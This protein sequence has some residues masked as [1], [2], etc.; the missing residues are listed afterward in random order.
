[1]PDF[2]SAAERSEPAGRPASPTYDAHV[3]IGRLRSPCDR[4]RHIADRHTIIAGLP[5]SRA[6]GSNPPPDEAVQTA[7]DVL[8]RILGAYPVP[9][10]NPD[11]C[12]KG[13]LVWW[14][15]FQ[16]TTSCGLL[17]SSWWSA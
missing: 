17:W 7:L 6:H 4:R 2:I 12:R 5:R 13:A 15:N 11:A 3:L 1:M 9:A 10:L 16:C 8:Q 14:S